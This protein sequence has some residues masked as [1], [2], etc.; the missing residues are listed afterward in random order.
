MAECLSKELAFVAP[1]IKVLIVEPGY[2]GTR[3]FHNVNFAP[4]RNAV[5]YSEFLAGAKAHVAS[6][7]DN[8]PGDPDKAVD[9]MIELVKGT[10]MAAGRDVPLRV[11]LGSDG[12]DKVKTKCKETLKIC[13]EWAD[14]ASSIDVKSA[15]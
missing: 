9:R 11:P 13:E 15:T 8:E 10:G 12:W 2:C 6:V 1:G 3:A 14:V 5:D 4:L 7:V